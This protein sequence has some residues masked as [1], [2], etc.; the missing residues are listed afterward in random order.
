MTKRFIIKAAFAAL[1]FLTCFCREASAQRTSDGQLYFDLS[2][3]ASV[4]SNPSLGCSARFGQYMLSSRWEVGVSGML[5][6]DGD[7]YF[8]VF[9]E[10]SY[11]LRFCADRSRAVHL[12]GG[13]GI[14]AGLEV[15]P[16]AELT[17]DVGVDEGD[18]SGV[19]IDFS[20]MEKVEMG[21][22]STAM[23]YGVLPRLEAEVFIGR[24][25]ALVGAVSMPLTFGSAHGAFNLIG[26]VG[27]RFN[28]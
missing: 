9:A 17:P 27:L 12:Y 11:L 28:L 1:L 16:P 20:E 15:T 14:L 19:D 26:S 4:I 10:A 13:I 7:K 2:G 25:V 24:K 3:S 21:S 23:I 22:A 18:G 8:P 6:R 5:K